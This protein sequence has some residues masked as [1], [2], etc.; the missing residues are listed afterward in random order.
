V[1]IRCTGSL[2]ITVSCDTVCRKLEEGKEEEE[3]ANARD[4]LK[5]AGGSGLGIDFRSSICNK[6]T[7]QPLN[8]VSMEQMELS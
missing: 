6:A 2:A 4:V 5:E 1:Q 3:G 8:N 7:S